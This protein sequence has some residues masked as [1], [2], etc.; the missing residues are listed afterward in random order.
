VENAKA[1]AVITQKYKVQYPD[2]IQ[3]KA[4]ESVEVARADE[5]SPG[6]YWCRAAD[7]REGWMPWELLSSQRSPAVVLQDYSAKEL[8]VQPG[9]EVEV[10]E[11]RHDWVLVKNAEG[12]LGWVPKSHIDM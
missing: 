10:Q 1:K 7:G 3:V 2:P 6:W 4:G 8:A 5:D 11:V 12:E 9:D